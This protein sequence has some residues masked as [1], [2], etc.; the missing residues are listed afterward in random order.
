MHY[1]IRRSRMMEKQKF[2]ITSLG[3]LFMESKLDPLEHEK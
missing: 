2:S 1:V 3:T